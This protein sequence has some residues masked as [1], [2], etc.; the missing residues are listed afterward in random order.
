M[1]VSNLTIQCIPFSAFITHTFEALFVSSQNNQAIIHFFPAAMYKLVSD[2]MSEFI[3]K[4]V[5]SNNDFE[6]T[7]MN[8]P[9]CTNHKPLKNIDI[10][11]KECHNAKGLKLITRLWLG[12]SHLRF[13]K[14]KHSFQDTLNLK[15]C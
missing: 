15:L 4:K 5:L 1:L 13:H 7:L 12:L 11:A 3:K 2:F 9:N 8:I 6:I 14:Y 10:G